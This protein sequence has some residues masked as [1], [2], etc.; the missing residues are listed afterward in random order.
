[1]SFGVL[2]NSHLIKKSVM[3]ELDALFPF[4]D[5]CAIEMFN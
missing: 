2:D 5:E 1:M 3:Q 4:L